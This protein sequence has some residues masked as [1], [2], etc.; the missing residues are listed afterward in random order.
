MFFSGKLKESV[1]VLF[2]KQV[3]CTACDDCECRSNAYPSAGK[4]NKAIVSLTLVAISALHLSGGTKSSRKT[5]SPR[6]VIPAVHSRRADC[7]IGGSRR[8]HSPGQTRLAIHDT[9]GTK[10]SG[11]TKFVSFKRISAFF[12]GTAYQTSIATGVG[13]GSRRTIS[14][15]IHTFLAECLG[16]TFGHFY[17][18]VTSESGWTKPTISGTFFRKPAGWT[19]HAIPQTGGAKFSG[20]TWRFL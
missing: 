10:T 7:A 18:F 5:W 8:C 9:F 4:K 11:G 16:G 6:R 1:D 12:S 20:G 2:L 3:S 14:A 13:E 15:F 19:K 17:A